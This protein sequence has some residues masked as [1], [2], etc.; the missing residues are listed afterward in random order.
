[1]TQR[2][3]LAI[4]DRVI[5]RALTNTD[6]FSPPFAIR[7]LALIPFLRRIPAR[8]IGLGVRPEHVHT[9][10]AKITPASRETA[11]H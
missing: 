11:S 10:D 7:L 1:M 4:Q 6:G 8:M 9:S 5:R 2:V 3:Q